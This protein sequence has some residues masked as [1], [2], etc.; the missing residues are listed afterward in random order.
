MMIEGRRQVFGFDPRFVVDFTLEWRI[1]Q[2]HL[3]V[4][5]TIVPPDYMDELLALSSFQ[6]EGIT[7]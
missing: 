5:S 7:E 4:M 1:D 3:Q 6:A 2:F